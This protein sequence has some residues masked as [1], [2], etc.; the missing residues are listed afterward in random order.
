[1]KRS[2]AS[3]VLCG[4]DDSREAKCY[5]NSEPFIYEKSRAVARLL[6]N[7]TSACTGWL[8]GDDGHLMTN[9]H[10]VE[11]TTTANNVT[12]EFMAEGSNCDTDCRSWFGCGG[13]IEATST[14]LVRVNANLD[15]ALLQLPNNVS[16][17]YG[18]LQLREEGATNGERIYIPQHPQ[19][20]GKRIAVESTDTHDTGGFARVHSLSEPRCGGNG[21]DVGYY[22]DTQGGSSGSPVLGYDDNLVIALHHCGSCP[23]RGVPIQEIIN[24]LGD[25]LPKNAIGYGTTIGDIATLCH[26]NSKTINLNNNQNN[27]TTWQVSSNVTV[28]SSNNNSITVKAS[29]SNST[30]N[31]WIKATL[32]NGIILQED[33]QVGVPYGYNNWNIKIHPYPGNIRG[34]LY[35]NNWTRVWVFES[36]SGN[37]NWTAN[38]SMIRNSNYSQILIK[39]LSRG[40]MTIKARLKNECGCGDW[41][42]KDYYVTQLS[43]GGYHFRG[44][45]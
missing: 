32:S 29:S 30:G 25:D 7:G 19:A 27:S 22:A 39:P 8:V 5:L 20:W 6:I 41:L 33:F 36:P 23:N 15:Y 14:T 26:N 37:W 35:L 2:H 42:A 38:Y 10:C 18:F 12:V 44:N 3:E 9:E 17:K 11:N 45:N 13:I 28:L 31:G 34:G 24:N 43:G 21:N 4:P 1:M 16:N 40:Y